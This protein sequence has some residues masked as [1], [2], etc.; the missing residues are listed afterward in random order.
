MAGPGMAEGLRIQPLTPE[1]WPDLEALFGRG[2]ASYGCWCMFFRRTSTEMSNAKAVDNKADLRAL[3]SAEPAPGLLAYDG[4][5]AVG[6]VGLGPRAAFARLVR[7]RNLK[8][9]DD[10]PTWSVV[11]FYIARQRRGQG[12]ARSLLE[13]AVRYSQANGAP[14]IEGYARDASDTRLSADGAYPGTVRLFEGAGFREVARYLPPG[15]GT[16]RVTMRRDLDAT[17]ATA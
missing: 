2:G 13:G 9:V 11:C 4:S 15:G 8:Q 1:R 17:S 3:A 10:L 12:I 14:A 7:S 5:D 6:W 16:A